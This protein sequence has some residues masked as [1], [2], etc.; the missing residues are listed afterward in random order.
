MKAN[1]VTVTII[2]EVLSTDSVPTLISKVADNYYAEFHS[3][4]VTASDGD[5]VSWITE[6]KRVEF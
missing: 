5:S 1:K 6:Q 4:Q 3:G 2:V